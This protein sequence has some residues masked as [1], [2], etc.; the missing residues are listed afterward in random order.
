MD[1]A[2]VDTGV[3]HRP[4]RTPSAIDVEAA[5]ADAHDCYAPWTS[6]IEV[7][8][9]GG[10][11]TFSVGIEDSCDWAVRRSSWLSSASNWGGTVTWTAAA[12]P[13]D[14]RLGSISVGR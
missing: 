11:G 14:A 9:S 6:Q 10:G 4:Q 1:P 5:V 3:T 8:V 13:D 7:P 12:N 2:S